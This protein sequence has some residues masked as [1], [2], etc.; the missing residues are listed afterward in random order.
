MFI[1][2]NHGKK[3]IDDN[4]MRWNDELARISAIKEP[5]DAWTKAVK[6]AILNPSIWKLLGYYSGTVEEREVAPAFLLSGLEYVMI[7]LGLDKNDVAEM[8]VSVSSRR[9]K[10]TGTQPL[11]WKLYVQFGDGISPSEG[12]E[13]NGG[14]LDLQLIFKQ[15]RR[16]VELAE[17]S[18]KCN[19]DF[20]IPDF[21]GCNIQLMINSQFYQSE[22]KM[23]RNFNGDQIAVGNPDIEK[24]K[25]TI[26]ASKCCNSK[27]VTD[28]FKG[29]KSSMGSTQSS[30]VKGTLLSL[31]G[32]KEKSAEVI[33][34]SDKE[35]HVGMPHSYSSYGNVFIIKF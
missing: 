27:A 32:I 1:Q 9:W 34:V 4:V 20:N 11:E 15:R 10:S 8:E 31:S 3:N 6:T 2:T 7:V 12:K 29:F 25:S 23:F 26:L 5:V 13:E 22:G 35:V 14:Y 30:L 33:R 18:A 28:I 17:I 16:T 24:F 19:L 21:L